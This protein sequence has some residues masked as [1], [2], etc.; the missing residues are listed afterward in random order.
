LAKDGTFPT[1]NYFG[2]SGLAPYHDFDSFIPQAVKD[3]MSQIM[4]GLSDGSITTSYN[5]G[6]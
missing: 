5:P 2:A 4:S 6:G 1:G 3:K